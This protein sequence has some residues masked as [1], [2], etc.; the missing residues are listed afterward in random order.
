MLLFDE[1]FMEWNF[2]NQ[3]QQILAPKF[4]PRLLS[5][6]WPPL[7][8]F[9][10]SCYL[11]SFFIEYVFEILKTSLSKFWRQNS[12]RGCFLRF[13]LIV[14]VDFTLPCGITEVFSQ[15]PYLRCTQLLPGYLNFL[16]G[17]FRKKLSHIR[18]PPVFL[19]DITKCMHVLHSLL[20]N[21]VDPNHSQFRI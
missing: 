14:V 9:L 4:K 18:L 7:E 6:F 16:R 20:S 13:G 12:N 19:Y 21:P 3:L 5:P 1:S 10:V 8:K 17:A 15:A 11:T 2:E